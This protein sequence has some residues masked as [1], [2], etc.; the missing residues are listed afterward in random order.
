MDIYSVKM[1]GYFLPRREAYR[2]KLRDW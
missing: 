2:L 1:L